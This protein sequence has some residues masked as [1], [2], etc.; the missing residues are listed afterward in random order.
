MVSGIALTS[1]S[2]EASA[3]HFSTQSFPNNKNK[4]FSKTLRS[5]LENNDELR[6]PE[7]LFEGK[8][9]VCERASSEEIVFLIDE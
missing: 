6:Q 1:H 9:R 7:A 3:N 2:L 4:I 8:A 5:Q